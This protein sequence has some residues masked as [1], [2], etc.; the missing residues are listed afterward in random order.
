[1]KPWP[2][3]KLHVLRFQHICCYGCEY[4]KHLQLPHSAH[5]AKFERRLKSHEQIRQSSA[6]IGS[7]K[8]WQRVQS[9]LAKHVYT[10]IYAVIRCH[11]KVAA[12]LSFEPQ[13]DS[14]I[15]QCTLKSWC[16]DQ[17]HQR[18]NASHSFAL[19]NTRLALCWA[20]QC[21]KA[22]VREL[23]DTILCMNTYEFVYFVWKYGTPIP[24]DYQVF[25]IKMVICW[26]LLFSDKHIM[27]IHLWLMCIVVACSDASYINGSE[28]RRLWWPETA[29]GW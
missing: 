22:S 7:S 8:A 5:C 29:L 28:L 2:Q 24:M 19:L 26:Y 16:P 14:P 21:T 12:H 18:C 13:D 4:N 1:M 9:A 27:I 10:C 20:I 17:W 11:G 15:W 3:Q 23:N 25:P 6:P